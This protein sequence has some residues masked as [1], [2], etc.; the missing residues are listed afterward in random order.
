M[1][2]NYCAEFDFSGDKEDKEMD[3][4]FLYKPNG[5]GEESE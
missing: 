1:L 5:I 4:E 2:A 3:W